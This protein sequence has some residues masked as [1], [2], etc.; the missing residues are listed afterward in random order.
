MFADNE[1]RKQPGEVAIGKQR[2]E[3]FFSLGQRR[4]RLLG[5]GITFFGSATQGRQRGAG[6]ET[7]SS[8]GWG[9]GIGG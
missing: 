6:E 7:F 3:L 9:D 1:R 5:G 8:P 2:A 4:I